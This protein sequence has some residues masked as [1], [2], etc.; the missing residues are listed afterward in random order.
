MPEVL[1]WPFRIILYVM[2]Y[3]AWSFVALLILA[4]FPTMS[5]LEAINVLPAGWIPIAAVFFADLYF[6]QLKPKKL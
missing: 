3:I 2:L 1:R 4:F 6:T 5:G